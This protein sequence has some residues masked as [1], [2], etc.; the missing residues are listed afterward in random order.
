MLALV[1]A[2]AGSKGVP[3]KALRTVGGIPMILRTLRNVCA[4]GVADRVV[5]TT[6]WSALRDFCELRGFE[7][8]T[9]PDELAEP[10][11]P[12]S[13]VAR[14][15]VQELEWDGTVG[16]FQ[17]TCP[18]LTP[19]TVS[20]SVERFEREGWDWAI[21]AHEDQRIHWWGASPLTDRVNRQQLAVIRQ[22]SGAVQ[23]M[24]SDYALTGEGRCG[25]LPIT[26][27]EGLDVDT[28][29]DLVLAERLAG[30][31]RIHFV[32]AAG[33]QV[34]TG[35]Y[36]RCS[37]LARVLSHHDL[38]WEWAGAGALMAPIPLRDGSDADVTVFDRL[39]V[40][41]DDLLAAV[42]RGKA[43]VLE[44]EGAESG[45][46]ADLRVN[47]MLDRADL[48]YVV[49]REEFTCLPER[50]HGSG[51]HI[52]ATFGGT[53]PASLAARVIHDLIGHNVQVISPG[54]SMAKEMR[55][56]DLVVTGQGR[57][58][59]EA[60]ACGTPC[61]SIAANER[62]ARHVR[63]PG[64]T[65]LGLHTTVAPETI[66]HAVTETLGSI[67]LRREMS[68]TA[69]EALDDR[70]ADRLARAIEELVL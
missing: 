39:A 44:D 52:L 62:E 63:I 66:R 19:E 28:P 8:L 7:T 26:V 20:A 59:M 4:S 50:E 31:R 22:E 38:S 41:R 53:D 35:H 16:I 14:H 9:R 23:L 25:T 29:D 57:T 37:H 36:H 1:P 56:A 45:K 67:D 13:E 32:V 58:V 11:V 70:G 40:P 10:D 51:R 54:A 69:R 46:L 12:L 48:R 43:V 5:V 49:L 33:E 15:A 61:I 30:L 47:D 42:K 34:G 68:R 65:Y 18:L 2:R 60:A 55:K 6:D 27:R 17:P 3:G 24:T 64:V 21:T